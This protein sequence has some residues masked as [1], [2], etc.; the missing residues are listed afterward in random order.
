LTHLQNFKLLTSLIIRRTKYVMVQ[1]Q[2][3]PRGAWS[4]HVMVSCRHREAPHEVRKH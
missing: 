2:L 3:C 4:L 1:W